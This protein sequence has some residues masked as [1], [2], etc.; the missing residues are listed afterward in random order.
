MGKYEV[1]PYLEAM[2]DEIEISY[3]QDILAIILERKK[4]TAIG[5][6]SFG[7]QNDATPDPALS[8][9]QSLLLTSEPALNSASSLSNQPESGSAIGK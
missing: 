4:T 1:G 8:S 6:N 2:K 3:P 9:A 7:V 5:S